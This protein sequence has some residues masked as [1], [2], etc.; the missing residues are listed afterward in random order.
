MIFGLT[1][2]NLFCFLFGLFS[3]YLLI[4]NRR[5]R[6]KISLWLEDAVIVDAR[7]REVHQRYGNP[8]R[9]EVAFD[10]SGKKCSYYSKEGN[11]VEG[12]GKFFMKYCKR[13]NGK[14]AILYSPHYDQV[15]LLK[16]KFAGCN[17][18]ESSV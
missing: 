8:Y 7:L 9:I 6:N 13:S 3:V 10:Y 1:A 11:R 15:L 17:Q 16:P 12:Y 18:G 4:K 5:L 2:A 14:S